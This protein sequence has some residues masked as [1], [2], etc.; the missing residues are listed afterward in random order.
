MLPDI[1]FHTDSVKCMLA[2]ECKPCLHYLRMAVLDLDESAK[3]DPLKVLL[4]L[5]VNE[6]ASRDRPAFDD[7]RKRDGSRDRKIEIVCGTNGEIGKEL[8]VSDTVGSQLEVTHGKT[9]FRFPP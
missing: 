5:F 4:A 2:K 3:G 1:C 6:V 7:A 9:I 8:H